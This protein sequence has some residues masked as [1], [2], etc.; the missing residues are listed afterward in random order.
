M[1]LPYCQPFDI[2]PHLG[3]FM[4]LLW[5]LLLLVWLAAQV[6]FLIPAL[7]TVSDLFG[8]SQSVAG[9][10]FLAFGNGCADLFSMMSATLSGSGGLELAIGEVLG[11]GMFVFCGVQGAVAL[12]ATFSVDGTEYIRDCLVYLLAVVLTL[13]V[14]ADGKIDG[15]EGAGSIFSI[16]AVDFKARVCKRKTGF[17]Y[18]HSVC[19]GI[20]ACR[21]GKSTH[22]HVHVHVYVRIYR[23]TL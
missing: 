20:C 11:N 15:W 23:C 3:G 9:V 4:L 17:V 14:L 7:H 16:F 5:T 2:A 13:A 8:M 19:Q 12:T 1:S 18:E 21:H 22:L 10:T 6:D